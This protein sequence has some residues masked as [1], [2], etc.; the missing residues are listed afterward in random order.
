MK[1]TFQLEHPKIKLPR[2][3]EATK[4]E[5]KKYLRRERNKTLPEDAG[6]W[7]FDCQFGASEQ[8]AQP[9]HVKEI[10]QKIDEAETQGLTSF[11][12][13]ILAKPG[14]KKA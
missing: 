8:S 3:Y 9:V 10:N 12:I 5:V 6:Y 1:K 14:K 11:Y 4:H 13:Q 7:D 2:M